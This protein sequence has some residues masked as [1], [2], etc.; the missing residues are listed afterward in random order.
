MGSAAFVFAP[1]LEQRREAISPDHS[2]MVQAPA[3]SGKTELLIQR[4][5][6]LLSTVEH[7]ESIVAITFTRKAAGEMLDRVLQS[8]RQA[9]QGNIPESAHGKL[10][11]QLAEDA[12][13]QDQRY[14]WNLLENPGRLRIQTIDS[15]CI[16]IVSQMPWLAR[17]GAV[18]RIEENARSLY[19]EAARRTLMHLEEN[20]PFQ[21]ALETTLLHL[22]NEMGRA[23][24]LLADM[25]GSRDQWIDLT[26]EVNED[27]RPHLE[28]ALK[29]AVE[30]GLIAADQLIPA[31]LHHSWI[32]LAQSSETEVPI[33][34]WPTTTADQK[35]Q[36]LA[37][38]KLVLTE[39]G[40]IRKK[41]KNY[42]ELLDSLAEIDGA[43]EALFFIRSLPA[44]GYTAAHWNILRSLLQCLQLA[45]AELRIVFSQKN[46]VDFIELGLAAR[47]AL[48]SPEAPTDLAFRMDQR[49]MHLLV[50]EFQDTSVSQYEL[51]SQLTADWQEGD[52][53][54]LFLVGDPMQSIY[55][56][57]QAE[58]GLFLNVREQ[59][60]SSIQPRFLQL[61]AN[62]RS[63]GGIVDWVNSCFSR[64]FPAV[65]DVSSGAI[66]YSPSQAPSP[67]STEP[68][69]SIHAF[70]EGQSAEEARTVVRLVQEAR[71]ADPQGSVAI[72][73]RARTHLPSIV[74]ELRAAGLRF[75]AV[76]IDPL[77]SRMGVRDLLSLTR[78]MLHRGDRISWLSILRAPWCGLDLQDL[79]ALVF[80]DRKQIIWNAMQNAVG[81]STDGFH[82]VQRMCG[83]LKQAFEEQGRW[84]LRQW[85]ERT[86]LALNGPACL[87]S[88]SELQDAMDFFDLLEKEESAGDLRDFDAFSERVSQLFAQPDSRAEDWLQVMTI[89][90][91]KG[92]QFDTVILPGLGRSR[93][94]DS[95]Q[96]FY[97]HQWMDEE[98]NW[99]RLLAPMTEI[100]EEKD[101]SCKYLQEIHQQ[102]ESHEQV[103]LLY[104]ATTRAKK[105]LHLLANAKKTSKGELTYE[106]SSMLADLWPSFS[107]EVQ[108]QFHEAIQHTQE[109]K[110]DSGS[111]QIPFRR[112][113]LQWNTPPLPAPV[114]WQRSIPVRQKE[115]RPEYE[116]VGD[117]LRHA[118][119]AVHLFLQQM[120]RDKY[121]LPDMQMIRMTLVH[122][123]VSDRDLDAVAGRVLKALRNVSQS[124]RGQWILAEH[125]ND[126]YEY[127]LSGLV[128]GA[129]VRGTIDRTFL[130]EDG[131]RWII[132]Y[133][134]SS[135]L[136]S[137]LNVFL[138]E[139]QRRYHDQMSRY[140]KLLAL[141]GFPVRLGI[142]FPL[143]DEWREWSMEDP[144]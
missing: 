3:G 16:S 10:T 72:L 62:Y 79:H 51:L 59:G 25:L 124:S 115:Y 104:V 123:G 77:D 138:D 94:R 107:E 30:A 35:D 106:K 4:F 127:S 50:D 58:V 42:Q 44:P 36:W 2:F 137:D 41:N 144:V 57:R 98:G 68:A 84:P 103:R 48:G 80:S 39:K 85:V 9:Q 29:K 83:I 141:Q 143:L 17:L 120:A 15:L 6:K 142:Y 49:I 134:T 18:P 97:F 53:R 12:L 40:T 21:S 64:I 130:D 87:E 99:E 19:L 122:L 22:D 118:G 95:G 126:Q 114:D 96:L 73:V 82:R 71:L 117:Q 61:V 1:D 63:Q 86:W 78:A 139:Q 28:N 129:I 90:K 140:G 23:T 133:K 32:S 88:Q 102:K 101:P 67:D 132:D 65:N 100:G 31:H 128:S 46:T 33:D 136:G 81:L 108:Q 55:R 89:H 109:L 38:A 20:G 24:R 27:T 26:Y 135:H 113:P 52:G 69:V 112:L 54:T 93:R 13:Q 7:P 91:S 5:L 56:F 11:Q 47:H 34:Q 74:R 37:L 125:A 45:V 105:K 43:A 110:Q 60:I 76:E 121:P 8:L 111:V 70:G 14:G 131:V 75:R 92:L 66:S 116:W 119:T